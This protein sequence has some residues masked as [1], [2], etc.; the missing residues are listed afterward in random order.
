MEE[1]FMRFAKSAGGFS[2]IFH[3]FGA[4]E[5]WCR[6]TSSRA[7]YHEKLLEMCGLND[8]PDCPRKGK[9]REME[10]AEIERSKKAVIRVMAAKN[11]CN[12]FETSDKTKLYNLASGA[13]VPLNVEIDLMQAE[14][15]GNNQKNKFIQIRLLSGR[16]KDFFLNL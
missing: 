9:H 10:K 5:R 2:G 8:D 16:P 14:V 1:T 12:P 15:K 4:Y 3:M 13:P 6:T 7:Q 11:V